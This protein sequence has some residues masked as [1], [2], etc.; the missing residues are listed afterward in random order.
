MEIQD[1]LDSGELTGGFFGDNA[2]PDNRITKW[3]DVKA[4][5]GSARLD[6]PYDVIIPKPD[7]VIAAFD[8]VVINTDGLTVDVNA[9]TITV[10]DAGYYKFSFSFNGYFAGN[11]DMKLMPFI[12]G[13][14]Y[15]PDPIIKSGEGN[16][17]NIVVSWT[18]ITQLNA[19]DV[20]DLRLGNNDTSQ[21]N[22][23]LR[24]KRLFFGVELIK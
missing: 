18:S 3:K 1:I 10:D 24:V 12:N 15:S 17:D 5:I 13:N 6:V 22:I 14:P 16:N 20:I 9:H 4:V 21:G 11:D 7:Y 2:N 19:G 23:N 8:D